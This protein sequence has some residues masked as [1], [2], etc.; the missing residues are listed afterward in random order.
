MTIDSQFMLTLELTLVDS[1]GNSRRWLHSPC[2]WLLSADGV[3][4][5]PG[6]KWVSSGVDGYRGSAGSRLE[7]RLAWGVS[8]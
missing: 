8:G 6:C 2:T 3:Q 7:L 1:R 4:R 5:V